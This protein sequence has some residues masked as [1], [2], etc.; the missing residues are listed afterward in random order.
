M[1][2]RLPITLLGLASFGIFA[3]YSTEAA[4]GAAPASQ[5]NRSTPEAGTLT[6]T[7]ERVVI[8]KDGYGLFVKAA[9]AT[10]DSQGVVRTD[11]VPEAAVLGTFWAIPQE[12]ALKSSIA[13]WVETVKTKNEEGS[14]LSTQELLRANVGKTLTLGRVGANPL[15]GKIIEVLDAPAVPALT[16]A[17]LTSSGIEAGP[18][19][20]PLARRGGDFFVIE[21]ADGPEQGRMV[22][23]ISY[24]S[25]LSGKEVITHCVRPSEVATRTKRLSFDFGREAAG[26][27]VTLRIFY[28]TPGVRWIPTYRVDTGNGAKAELSLQAEIRSSIECG[29][30][31]LDVC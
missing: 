3:T 29:A 10:A 28:F 21:V 14:C 31:K 5:Q 19:E 18:Y 12:R 4:T 20:L 9:T 16:R 6:L 15:T 1:P 30:S 7:T 11:H 13:D 27:S 17:Q 26:K 22:L 2:L 23:P 8:F 24:V 25:S